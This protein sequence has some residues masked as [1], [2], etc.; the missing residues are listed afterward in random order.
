MP[1]LKVL[2]MTD[3]FITHGGMNSIS[4][5]LYHG[6]P[7]VVIPCTADQPVNA[8]RIE[9]LKLGKTLDYSTLNKDVIK[10]CVNKVLEDNQI[11]NNLI[12]IQNDI[13]E[14]PGNTG[15]VDLII[16]YYEK[17]SGL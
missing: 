14:A 7:M 8:R 11:K 3:V 10:E 16:Q 6:V 2:K 15:A 1:Q 9:Q 12:K 13:K 17:C 5:A 4:E